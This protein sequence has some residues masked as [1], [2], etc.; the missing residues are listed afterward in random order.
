MY[1]LK[2]RRI[3]SSD[4]F[5]KKY[6]D[7]YQFTAMCST[8]FKLLN[9]DSFSQ[10]DMYLIVYNI[11]RMIEV[12][13]TILSDKFEKLYIDKLISFKYGNDY[14]KA[15]YK[16]FKHII[17]GYLDGNDDF[18]DTIH[19]IDIYKTEYNMTYVYG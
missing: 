6:D 8:L 16:K 15:I 7:F 17:P 10:L 5:I 14:E 4:M 1:P 19:D 9:D 12:N 3:V 13:L 2:Y 11:F 18:N